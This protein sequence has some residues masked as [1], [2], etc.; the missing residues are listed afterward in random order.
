[1]DLHQFWQRAIEYHFVTPGPI[2]FVLLVAAL[3]VL[4]VR[5]LIKQ[6]S[7]QEK[8]G[9]GAEGPMDADKR[10]GRH[11]RRAATALSARLALLL[12]AVTAKV[13]IVCARANLQR[14]EATLVAFS[15]VAEHRGHFPDRVMYVPLWTNMW[16][17]RCTKCRKVAILTEERNQGVTLTA[18]QRAR[19]N[20]AILRYASNPFANVCTV[21]HV[22]TSRPAALQPVRRGGAARPVLR[23]VANGC[24]V[25]PVP[26]ETAPTT[27]AVA[28]DVEEVA[29]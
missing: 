9:K 28:D 5:H 26:H 2:L 24:L 22:E 16:L 23:R 14:V 12:L 18:N 8:K 19:A 25:Q 3:L 27:A 29:G 1:M 11:I 4:R 13:W 10:A 17:V 21:G 6:V 7:R 20:T 15:E